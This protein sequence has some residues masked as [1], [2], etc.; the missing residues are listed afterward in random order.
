MQRLLSH[1]A[2]AEPAHARQTRIDRSVARLS[3]GL[4]AELPWTYSIR[5]ETSN[6][7]AAIA[8]IRHPSE[9]GQ[10]ARLFAASLEANRETRAI[11]GALRGLAPPLGSSLGKC[12][13]VSSSGS[14][15]GAGFGSAIDAHDTVIRFNMAP[16]DGKYA[17]DV[18][19]KTTIMF[20]HGGTTPA[21]PYAQG[22]YVTYT[23]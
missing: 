13:V 23:K 19:V 8:G 4:T 6:V 5:N 16:P 15:L 9:G 12:A 18:G 22:R 3:Y 11:R 21:D 10:C 1:S 2:A 14:L 7:S 20:G 17:A